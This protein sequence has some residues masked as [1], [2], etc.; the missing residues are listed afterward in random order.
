[1]SEAA[2]ELTA[3]S[4]FDERLAPVEG[5]D[6]R[7]EQG[8]LFGLIGPRGSGK[9]TLMKVLA[10]L[11]PPA[12]GHARIAGMELSE[13]PTEIRRA[14]G[15]LPDFFGIYDDLKVGEMLTFYARAHGLDEAQTQRRITQL[16][17]RAD[18]QGLEQERIERLDR[19]AKH[20]LQLMRVLLH[21]PAVLLLDDPAL[22]LA[23]PARERLG[24]LI[25]S[26]RDEGKTILLGGNL[27]SDVAPICD[28]LAVL[29]E[30]RKLAQGPA[31]E[32]A[33]KLTPGRMIEVKALGGPG[34]AEKIRT[35]LSADPRVLQAELHAGNVVF[36]LRE[37]HALPS[38]VIESAVAAGARIDAYREHGINV[39]MFF[40]RAM[41]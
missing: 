3:L 9:S 18:L 22:G 20:R 32:I 31:T 37:G 35:I 30:G 26:L 14:I 8:E 40:E 13:Q 27:L 12:G 41:S 36:N 11:R 19:E 25:R 34:E 6:L 17:E 28:R 1:M 39:G 33:N 24:K 5:L 38:P 29:H 10:T 16:L 7:V 4:T 15:Y 23:P 2:I 21:D